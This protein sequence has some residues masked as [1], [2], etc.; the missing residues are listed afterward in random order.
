MYQLTSNFSFL[1]RFVRPIRVTFKIFLATV[2]LALFST[3][4]SASTTVGQSSA[5]SSG[6]NATWTNVITL[7]TAS[8]GASSQGAQTLS[9]NVTEL[10][11]GGANYRVYKTTANGN[12]YF[13]DPQALVAGNNTITV[14]AVAFDRTVK[15]QLSSPDIGF[16]A[17]SVNESQL[18]P[19]IVEGGPGITVGESSAFIAG[20][21]NTWTNVITLAAISDGASSQG[22]QTLSINITELPANGANY[23]VYKTTAN[24]NDFFGN[25]Q[26]LG[27]GENNITV[28]AVG[29]DR[30][31]KIQ[32]SSSE[33]KFN[34]LSVNGTQLYPV[35]LDDSIAVGDSIA[36]TLD[37]AA[38]TNVIT[39]ANTTDGASSQTEQT[40]TINVTALPE[41]GANY[42]VYKTTANGNDFF[43]NSMALGVGENTISVTAVA[44]D[45]T[46][47]VQL[48]SSEIQYNLLTANENQLYPMLDTDHPGT[49]IGESSLFEAGPN[50]TWTNVITLTRAAD[51]AASQST[52][53][54]SLNITG[55]PIEGANYRVYKTN[56]AGNDYFGD[57]T[58]LFFGENIIS[59][60]EVDFDR[61]VKIQLSSSDVRFDTLSVNG[62][63]QYP[64]EGSWDFDNDGNADALT[65]GLLL[66]RY[67][68]NLKGDS[69]TNGAISPNSSITAAQVEAN[70]AASMTSFADIDGNGNVDALTDGLL[71]LRYLFNLKGDSLI[72]GAVAST[73]S[74]TSAPDIEAYILN[75]MP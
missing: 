50:E 18:Y 40:L 6:P 69:L 53:T 61:T 35:E 38:W 75:L 42:R 44:F 36:P 25:A 15:I 20:P 27:V 52:Q 66:L 41:G 56:S 4:A 62:A 23:R 10:P 70:V 72:N 30:T 54:L 37:P 1:P 26:S 29:F 7:T 32:L 13:A 2:L 24:G 19:V 51:G 28:A 3:A 65:D 33:V 64:S 45:R 49:S 58:T 16:D 59:I 12:D 31:V 22:E 47:K 57:A 34:N 39:L 74:R 48:S 67:A 21:N 46:V 60:S 68:F 17:L 14:E 9:I 73:A 43:G 55:L 63:Q 11:A 8:D 71:L 5:F